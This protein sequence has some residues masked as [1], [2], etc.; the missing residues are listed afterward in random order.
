ME[1]RTDIV[2]RPRKRPSAVLARVHGA[3]AGV[4]RAV[5]A[6]RQTGVP[7]TWEPV[8]GTVEVLQEV[9][10][11]GLLGTGARRFRRGLVAMSAREIPECV[12]VPG[13]KVAE[14]VM[15]GCPGA[16]KGA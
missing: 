11:K 7:S 14:R 5:A 9:T 3:E 15:A 1:S 10:E 13:V 8:H 4:P 16:G 12:G 6:R 2:I